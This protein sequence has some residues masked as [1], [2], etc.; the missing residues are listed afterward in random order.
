MN[1]NG[2]LVQTTSFTVPSSWIV[3]G[4]NSV[5]FVAPDGGNDVSLV[6]SI[7]L[8][9]PRLYKA[10]NNSLKSTATGS[11]S[12]LGRRILEF[13]DP[14]LRHHDSGDSATARW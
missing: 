7:S 14:R 2:E 1:F 12:L 3:P 9:Y 10:L 13:F 5:T 4:A 11:V 8:T 6:T